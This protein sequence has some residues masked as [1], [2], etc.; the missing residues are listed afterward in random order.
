M[1]LKKFT[2]LGSKKN[3]IDFSPISIMTKLAPEAFLK[4][5]SCKCK[6][7]VVKLADAENSCENHLIQIK[8]FESLS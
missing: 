2:K 8:L 6:K 4:F 5:I 3:K 7:H 1:N